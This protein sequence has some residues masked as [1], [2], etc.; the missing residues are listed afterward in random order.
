VIR[1]SKSSDKTLT[2]DQPIGS[3]SKSLAAGPG[4]MVTPEQPIGS[5]VDVFTDDN[6]FTG[7]QP[8][9]SFVVP[10]GNGFTGD[11]PIGSLAIDFSDLTVVATTPEQ[12]IGS[13]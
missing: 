13:H 12:P 3:K 4:D 5:Q 11:Q 10:G 7:D 8:I 9:G 6:G 2:G 1:I